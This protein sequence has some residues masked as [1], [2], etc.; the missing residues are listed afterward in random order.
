MTS[1]K[2]VLANFFAK[3]QTSRCLYCKKSPICK[4]SWGKRNTMLNNGTSHFLF[5]KKFCKA[6]H[7]FLMSR[8]LET[9]SRQWYGVK[10]IKFVFANKRNSKTRFGVR[11]YYLNY[12]L[13]VL[14]SSMKLISSSISLKMYSH[15]RILVRESAFCLF[16]FLVA[17]AFLFLD[18]R[19]KRQNG[20]FRSYESPV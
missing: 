13:I 7:P 15:G 3:C 1:E 8:K 5:C 4:I 20:D 2:N 6:S 11:L 12:R 16:S 9:Q 18:S 14:I 10:R 19:K 17:I